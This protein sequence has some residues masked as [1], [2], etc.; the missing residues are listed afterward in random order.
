MAQTR[1]F[2]EFSDSTG[3]ISNALQKLTEPS[4]GYNIPSLTS[5]VT[6]PQK[7]AAKSNNAPIQGGL[8]DQI[9]QVSVEVMVRDDH[10]YIAMS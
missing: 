2:I 9:L 1:F 5:Y 8:L 4:V 7:Q 3:E 6:Q 10:L